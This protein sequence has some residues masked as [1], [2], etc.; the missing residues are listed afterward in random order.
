MPTEFV[1]GNNLSRDSVI[2]AIR[3]A[4]DLEDA[5]DVIDTAAGSDSVYQRHQRLWW[6][7]GPVEGDAWAA[8]DGDPLEARLE[9][10]PARDSLVD[11][12]CTPR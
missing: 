7:L 8:E 6:A 11:L 2:A 4:L 1:G 12:G 10:G 9:G 3:R 5:L